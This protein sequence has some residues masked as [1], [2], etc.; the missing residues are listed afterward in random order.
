MKKEKW[1]GKP[2]YL[3]LLIPQLES[4]LQQA[5]LD[6]VK[7]IGMR[8]EAIEVK[9]S[10]AVREIKDLDEGSRIAQQYFTTR[11]LDRDNEILVP[12]GAIM[13]QFRASNMQ[14][15]WNHDYNQLIGSD[16]RIKRD[17]FGWIAWTK[18]AKHEDPGARANLV[19]ELKQQGHLKTNSVG[20]AILEATQ[21]GHSDWNAVVDTLAKEWPEFTAKM[22]KDTQRIITKYM[23][24][25]HSDVGVPSNVNA[26]MLAIA[27]NYGAKDADLER[28]FNI[29]LKDFP[30]GD[31]NVKTEAA[32]LAE[33]EKAIAEFLE[34]HEAKAREWLKAKDKPAEPP[35]PEPPKKPAAVRVPHAEIYRPEVR[36]VRSAISVADIQQAVSEGVRNALA[37]AQGK[38]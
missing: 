18:Y 34:Q 5:I 30:T 27:K 6:A 13:D 8:P 14:V 2:T 3:H 28:M 17:D 29:E 26:T 7:D 19:W 32:R 22:A 9:R 35:Q 38:V 4:T 31:P 33:E 1:P 11:T 36:L 16:D 37:L 24:I 23:V 25:E 21:P 15:F 10:G 12:K 20:F